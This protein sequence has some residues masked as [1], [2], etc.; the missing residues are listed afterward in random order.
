MAHTLV[1]IEDDD[2]DM[3]S[4][5]LGE[6]SL[7]WED[8]GSAEFDGKMWWRR[9]HARRATVCLP[10]LGWGF[11]CPPGISVYRPNIHAHTRFAKYIFRLR[12][13]RDPVV[14]LV[15]R[16]ACIGLQSMTLPE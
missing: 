11:F 7:V 12:R 15:T 1:W 13:E 16:E 10:R 3:A 2:V 6:T 8:A 5:E 14:G 9:S 4:S